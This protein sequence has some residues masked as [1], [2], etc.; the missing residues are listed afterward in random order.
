MRCQEDSLSF[1]ATYS[2]GQ[3]IPQEA[4]RPTLG[5][6]CFIRKTGAPQP[7]VMLPFPEGIQKWQKVVRSCYW[8]LAEGQGEGNRHPQMTVL[9]RIVAPQI[10][11][12]QC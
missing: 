12:I 4:L 3:G 1:A 2:C 8:L 7:R 11:I 9:Q 10:P 6:C 5:I